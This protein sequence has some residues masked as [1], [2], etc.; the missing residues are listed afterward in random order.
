LRKTDLINVYHRPAAAF[1]YSPQAI[2]IL[3]PTVQFTDQSSG[4]DQ[5]GIVSW[6]WNF[7]DPS[8]SP[9]KATSKLENPSHTYGDTGSFCAS[10]TVMNSHGCTDTTTNCLV[11]EPAF[12]LYIPSA[13]S[14][15]GDGL[16]D[17]FQ[18]VGKY[19]KTFEMY[20]FDRWGMQLYHTTDITQGWKGNVNGGSNIAQEETYIYKILVTDSQ[21]NAHSYTGNVSIIK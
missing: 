19:I 21:G 5:T 3:T 9:E 4:T 11:I 8:A 14:P 15:N 18:P 12:T 1:T 17:V 13:F 6:M 20:I 2:S 16:N 7:G 10:L